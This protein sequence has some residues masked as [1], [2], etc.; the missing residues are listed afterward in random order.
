MVA[1]SITTDV[2]FAVVIDIVMF[3][4]IVIVI[5][6]VLLVI[7]GQIIE[8]HRVSHN[9]LNITTTIYLDL[10]LVKYAQ[11]IL[12][13]TP[14]IREKK[15]NRTTKH[16]PTPGQTQSQIEAVTGQVE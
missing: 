5:V 11:S 15:A 4:V 8:K 10:P 9:K 16:Q 14:Y 13:Y 2:V 7:N 1:S 6:I 12:K 3:I